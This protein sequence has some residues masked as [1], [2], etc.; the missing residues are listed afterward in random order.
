MSGFTGCC[1]REGINIWIKGRGNTAVKLKQGRRGRGGGRAGDYVGGGRAKGLIP[2]S[3][4]HQEGGRV[5]TAASW[6]HISGGVDYAVTVQN[7]GG[8]GLLGMR[9]SGSG[10]GG[11][12]IYGSGGMKGCVSGREDVRGCV[13]GVDGGVGVYSWTSRPGEIRGSVEPPR[14]LSGVR[15]KR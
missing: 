7:V 14:A 4:L 15:H 13:G 9:D 11:D 3:Q 8:G 2:P 10:S 5:A 6:V 1:R 12:D